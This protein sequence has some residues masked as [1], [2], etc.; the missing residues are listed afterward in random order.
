MKQTKVRIFTA[1]F[2]T[3]F[4]MKIMQPYGFIKKGYELRYPTNQFHIVTGFFQN[5]LPD[6]TGFCMEDY[7]QIQ[8]ECQSFMFVGREEMLRSGRVW[9]IFAHPYPP[10]TLERQEHVPKPPTGTKF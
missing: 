7:T 1:I 3:K 4:C 8:R 6:V 2:S 5:R 9:L 10:L